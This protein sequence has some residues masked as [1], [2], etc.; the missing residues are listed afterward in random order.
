MA[1]PIGDPGTHQPVRGRRHPGR[2]GRGRGSVNFEQYGIYY[3]D[4]A[5]LDDGL[6]KFTHR[7][8]VPIY[9]NSGCVTGDA[10]T[11]RTALLRPN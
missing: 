3:D 9:V 11:Q 1:G 5:R 2:L 10:I 8:F 4:V 6:W 7:L